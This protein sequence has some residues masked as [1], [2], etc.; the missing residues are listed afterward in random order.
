MR[1]GRFQEGAQG[2]KARGSMLLGEF[3][4]CCRLVQQMH[5]DIL[6][7]KLDQGQIQAC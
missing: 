2:H 7:Q 3:G 1:R 5:I 4:C 6:E